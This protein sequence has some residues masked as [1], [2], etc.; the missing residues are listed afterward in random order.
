MNGIAGGN[1]SGK[2]PNPIVVKIQNHAVSSSTPQN[3]QLLKWVNNAWTAS[4]PDTVRYKAGQ[5]ITINKDT[6]S[7]IMKMAW[8]VDSAKRDAIKLYPAVTANIG[9]GTKNPTTVFYVQGGK[10]GRR[11]SSFTVNKNGNVGIGTDSV[12][13]K[14]K[15]SVKGEVRAIGITVESEWADYVF[16]STYQL[17]PL[18]E[19]ESFIHEHNHLPGVPSAGE[20]RQKG[21]NL[22]DAQKIMM[23]KIEELTLYLLELKKQNEQMAKEIEK[24]KKQK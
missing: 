5:G 7:S 17:K 24:L 21:L 4:N 19:V 15:L 13:E 10:T 2:Y 12:D 23:A 20:I 14:Y 22:G 1:L 11:D 16:D 18:N 8:V 9:I 6:I 3:G